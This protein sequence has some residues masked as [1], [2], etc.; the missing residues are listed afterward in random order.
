MGVAAAR[1]KGI[2]SSLS[3]SVRDRARPDQR[4]INAAVPSNPQTPPS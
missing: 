1:R 2:E 3:A 4:L